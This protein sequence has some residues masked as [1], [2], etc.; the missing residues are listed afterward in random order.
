MCREGF[1]MIEGTMRD[2][3]D[4]L[5][6]QDDQ[7]YTCDLCH[8]NGFIYARAASDPCPKCWGAGE[9]TVDLLDETPGE[10]AGA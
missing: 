1:V 8:G 5:E 6:F 7:L 9:V 4:D 10:W 3:D 2:I